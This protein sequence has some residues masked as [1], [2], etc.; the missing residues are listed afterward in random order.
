MKQVL[1]FILFI[2]SSFASNCQSDLNVDCSMSINYKGK[3]AKM[4]IGR[5]KKKCG[6]REGMAAD[7]ECLVARLC[8]PKVSESGGI[9]H[10]VPA[11][12]TSLCMKLKKPRKLLDIDDKTYIKV[13][14]KPDSSKIMLEFVAGDQRKTCPLPFKMP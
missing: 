5:F 8:G 12:L 7:H 14:C 3:K 11:Q 9:L 4:E 2:N 1:M 13:N 6:L 10:D